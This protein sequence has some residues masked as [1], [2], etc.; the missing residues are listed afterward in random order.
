MNYMSGNSFVLK[1][2]MMDL[3]TDSSAQPERWIPKLHKR[4]GRRRWES[5]RL[6]PYL[7]DLQQQ[8][9]TALPGRY[10]FNEAKNMPIL[11]GNGVDFLLRNQF[12]IPE[13]YRRFN[14]F[15]WGTIYYERTAGREPFVR[16]LRWNG[17]RWAE[18]D[19][20]VD[21]YGFTARCAALMYVHPGIRSHGNDARV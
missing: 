1:G 19:V 16:G 20:L 13:R 5:H 3:D 17:A 2:P 4:Q 11:N 15:G 14:L 12:L 21:G 18:L 10:L 7:T 8:G 6:L 9:V